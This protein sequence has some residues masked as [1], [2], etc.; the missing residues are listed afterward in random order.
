V[1]VSSVM[2]VEEVKAALAKINPDWPESAHE[3]LDAL[4]VNVLKAIALGAP[5]ACMLAGTA[6]EGEKFISPRW[7]S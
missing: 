7:Y 2:T 6:L 3:E 5:D 4:Y 1:T